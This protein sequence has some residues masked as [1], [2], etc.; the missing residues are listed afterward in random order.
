MEVRIHAIQLARL[1]WKIALGQIILHILGQVKL[2][3]QMH[4]MIKCQ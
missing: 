3:N 4:V 2:E 1:S